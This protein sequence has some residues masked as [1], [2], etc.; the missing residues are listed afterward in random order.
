MTID[1]SS[2][3][4]Q[5]TAATID[6]QEYNGLDESLTA[7]VETDQI[8]TKRRLTELS[9]ELIRRHVERL[10]EVADI[11]PNGLAQS[12]REWAKTIFRDPDT[13]EVD[14]SQQR[15]F[16]VIVSMFVLTFH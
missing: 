14:T 1:E 2:S 10:Q 3:I 11:N 15:A 9:I 5:Y 7:H 8:I 4:F 13:G 12:I 16:E 6:E